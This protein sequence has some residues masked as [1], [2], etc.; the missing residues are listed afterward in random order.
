M[1]KVKDKNKPP[2][3]PNKYLILGVFVF[4]IGSLFLLWT[5]GVLPKYEG[6]WPLPVILI[7]LFLLYMVFF[8]HRRDIYIIFGMVLTLGGIFLLLINTVISEKNLIKIWPAFMLITGISLLPYGFRKKK[9]IYNSHNHPCFYY[10]N[11]FISV[12]ILQS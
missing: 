1:N 7:G 10:Y 5:L 4:I 6:L 3:F 11:T 2:K 8:Q 12:S 9:E